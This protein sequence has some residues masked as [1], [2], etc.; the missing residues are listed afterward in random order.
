M[1]A[2]GTLNDNIIKIARRRKLRY[3]TIAKKQPKTVEAIRNRNPA[4]ASAISKSPS[5]IAIM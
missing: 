2:M 1:A 3:I 4:Q 5:G